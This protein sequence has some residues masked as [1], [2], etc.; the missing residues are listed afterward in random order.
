MGCISLSDG[1][2]DRARGETGIERQGRERE[3]GK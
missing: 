2:R 3:R 1:G